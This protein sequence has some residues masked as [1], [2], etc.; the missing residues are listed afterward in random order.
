MDEETHNN[1]EG[2]EN[3]S[4]SSTTSSPTLHNLV[5]LI[6]TQNV[7]LRQL[8]QGQQTIQQS[9]QKQQLQSS[10][11][12][13]HQ[14]QV[15]NY[16]EPNKETNEEKDIYSDSLL[17]PSQLPMKPSEMKTR[18]SKCSLDPIDLTGWEIS[19]AEF[20]PHHQHQ[21]VK[22]PDL[23]TVFRAR[24]LSSI[25]EKMDQDRYPTHEDDSAGMPVMLPLDNNQPRGPSDTNRCFNCGSPSHFFRNCSRAKTQIQGQRPIQIPR[26]NSRKKKI[27]RRRQRKEHRGQ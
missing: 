1:L 20:I 21:A 16:Q 2:F 17:P 5:E 14:L 22:T 8:F 6:A 19:C 13:I 23:D 7:L 25:K 24:T 26:N 15:T 18:N 10:G 11:Y 12:P 3:D 27:E 4:G 9:L